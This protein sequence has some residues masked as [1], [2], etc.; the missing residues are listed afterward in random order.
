M[1]LCFLPYNSPESTHRIYIYLY[2][3]SCLLP[4]LSHWRKQEKAQNVF[5]L[6]KIKRHVF[7]F[8]HFS[9]VTLFF[10]FLLG[11]TLILNTVIAYYLFYSFFFFPPISRSIWWPA[12]RWSS[13]LSISAGCYSSRCIPAFAVNHYIKGQFNPR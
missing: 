7:S 4:F 10:F 11:K 6:P 9:S 5:A 13:A 8:H 3:T 12:F 2:C 1:V